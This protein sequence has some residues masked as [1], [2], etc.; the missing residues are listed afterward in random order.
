MKSFAVIGLGSF[1]ST[2]AKSLSDMGHEV[3]AVDQDPVKVQ[4]IANDVT[5]AMT[6]DCRDADALKALGIQE[7]DNVVV[8][9]EDDF[10]TNIL[11]TL[12]LKDLNIKHITA[13]A[14]NELYARVLR[15]MG[16]ER[17]V[18]PDKDM[19]IKV[20]Q[21]LSSN[22]ILDYIELSD[23]FSIV[24]THV[25]R[26]WIGKS[27]RELNV[28]V[29]YGVTVVATRDEKTDRI[30]LSINPDRPFCE[31]DVL[32]VIGANDNISKL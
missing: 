30:D 19:G 25:P 8:A 26:K 17:I 24:E 18:F 27:L 12:M 15:Q 28:R 20:A 31:T 16:V 5:Q 2:L 29:N 11:V 22:N 14:E 7:F 4:N 10:E 13:K 1:G 6:A 3:L 23:E 21:S 32:V 9:L